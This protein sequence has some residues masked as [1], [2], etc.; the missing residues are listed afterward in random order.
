MPNAELPPLPYEQVQRRAYELYEQRGRQDGHH[1]ED[2]L[3]AEHDVRAA[4]LAAP[5]NVRVEVAPRSQARRRASPK[6]RRVRSKDQPAGPRR[7]AVS[8]KP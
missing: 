1:L 4:T 5:A 8:P 7:T 3:Q 2:W 6:P